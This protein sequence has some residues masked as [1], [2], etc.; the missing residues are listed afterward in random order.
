MVRLLGAVSRAH[1]HLY[2]VGYY[3]HIETIVYIYTRVAQNGI[4]YVYVTVL[5]GIVFHFHLLFDSHI[6]PYKII[7][8]KRGVY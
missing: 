4:V 1:L 3:I 8:P 5:Q 7:V 2:L 6:K